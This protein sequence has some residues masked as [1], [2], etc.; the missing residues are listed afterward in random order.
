MAAFQN[1]SNPYSFIAAPAYQQAGVPQPMPPMPQMPQPAPAPQR[2]GGIKWVQGVEGGKAQFVAPG[3][4][5]VFF[6]SEE[7]QFFIKTVDVSGM[8]APLRVF[9]YEEV[10]AANTPNTQEALAYVTQDEFN[11]LKKSVESLMTKGASDDE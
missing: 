11:A 2:V 8:P 9:R 7:Q 4:S 1:Y 5:D 3:S 10:V 6:D